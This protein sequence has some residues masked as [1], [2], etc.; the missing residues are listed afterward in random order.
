RLE[1]L[2]E[3]PAI[4]EPVYTF[5]HA[6]GQ[7]AAY[8]SLPVRRRRALHGRTARAMEALYGDR[9]EEHYGELAHHYLRSG[10]RTKALGYIQRASWQALQHSANAEAVTHFSNGLELLKTLPDTPARRR[11]E[12]AFYTRLGP[13]L[14][15]SRGYGAPEVQHA[16]L[17]AQELCEQFGD[18]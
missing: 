10:N 17:R 7:E 11:Q 3:R 15:A 1:L 2:Y 18:T 12:L 6:L 8:A 14:T 5:K 16:Y 4:P 9:L 13:A